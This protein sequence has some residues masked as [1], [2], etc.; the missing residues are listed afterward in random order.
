MNAWYRVACG[1]DLYTSK[2]RAD[3]MT[4]AGLK[5]GL[6]K[7]GSCSIELIDGT[8]FEVKARTLVCVLADRVELLNPDFDKV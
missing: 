4:W 2:S 1:G 6:K 5:I 7:R 8:T 3:A